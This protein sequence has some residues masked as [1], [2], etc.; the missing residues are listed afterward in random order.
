M[1]PDFEDEG[2]QIETIARPRSNPS[3][4]VAIVFIAITAIALGLLWY[5]ASRKKAPASASDET[6]HTAHVQPGTSFNA[7]PPPP[8]P[9][10]FVIPAP[11]PVAAP[12]APAP[13]AVPEPPPVVVPPPPV[14]QAVVQDD[15]EARREAELERQRKEEEAKRQA[16]IRSPM[17]V[18]NEKTGG[19]SLDGAAKVAATG[20]EEDSNRRFLNDAE[21]AVVTAHAQQIN[22][23]DA[24]VPQ[25]YMIKGVLETAIQSDLPGMVRASTSE[26]VYSFDGRRVLI[27]KGTMLTGEYRSGVLRGQTRV[28]VVWTRMLRA[29]G[30]S[31]MLGS[32]GTD[33]LGRSGLTGDVDNHFL[34]RFGGAALLTITGGVAQFVAALGN[35]QNSQ[36]TQYVL[37]PTT[38]TLVPLNAVTQNQIV[39]NGGQIAAQSM[40]QGITKMAEMALSNDINIPPTIN[41]DQ[42]T[43]IIVFVKRDLDFS[44]LYPDPVKEALYELRHPGKARRPVAVGDPAGLLPPGGEPNPPISARY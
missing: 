13:L 8:D 15:S 44:D 36:P 11:P 9:N 31:L 16:R 6:F 32:Y 30:V 19:P 4:G 35:L 10:K 1:P 37:D 42:G 34:Q 39:A 12:P 27:P 43:R 40:S 17:L 26:D 29:D 18:V 3:A 28:F 23:I 20:K 14:Q 41:V 38:N 7:L 22:R 24:L 25:G 2:R 21:G 33:Q 5:A